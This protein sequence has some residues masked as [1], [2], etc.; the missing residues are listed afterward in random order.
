MKNFKVLYFDKTL[1]ANSL[2][3]EGQNGQI[4][5]LPNHETI[6]CNGKLLYFLC[7]SKKIEIQQEGCVFFENNVL[8]VFL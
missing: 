2:F 8:S 6:F 4:C 1:Y 3:L 7:D 5:I